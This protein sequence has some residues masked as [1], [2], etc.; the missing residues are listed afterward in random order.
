MSDQRQEKR[1]SDGPSAS[2]MFRSAE[3]VQQEIIETVLR[4]ER[5]VMHQKHRTKIFDKI[6]GIIKERVQ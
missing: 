6:I 2:E 4:E 5:Q 1:G 3:R